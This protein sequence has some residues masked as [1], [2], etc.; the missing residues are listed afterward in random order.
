MTANTYFETQTNTAGPGELV[1]MLY[2]GAVR[3]L[4]SAIQGLE[5]KD[6]QIASNKLL[7]AQAI[8]TELIETLDM[9]QGGELAVNLGRIY[10]YM[11]Y[12]LADANVRKDAAPVREVEGLLRELLP[13]W[14]QA[15]RLT[16]A[17]PVRRLVSAAA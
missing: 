3:F 2:K 9:K 4:A 11:N 12:R 8:I 6:L 15:A 16:P 13:A 7:L 10:E 14:E 5:A 17:A 1:V